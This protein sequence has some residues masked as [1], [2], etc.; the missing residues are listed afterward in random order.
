M[1]FELRSSGRA[2]E[3]T[4]LLTTETFLQPEYTGFKRRLVRVVDRLSSSYR[5]TG[6]SPG[7]KAKDLLLVQSTS[8][9]VHLG[10]PNRQVLATVKACPSHRTDE[11]VS[12]TEGK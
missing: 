3:Q 4:A 1:G 11:L 10:I 5:N 8:L 7:R 9:G 2:P 12:K 6:W